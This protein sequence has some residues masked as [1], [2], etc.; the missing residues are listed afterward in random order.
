MAIDTF[1]LAWFGYKKN[2]TGTITGGTF[3]AIVQIQE[4]APTTLKLECKINAFTGSMSAQ[5]AST[6][7][8]MTFANTSTFNYA[9]GTHSVVLPASFITIIGT[10]AQN[11]Y[12]NFRL[13]RVGLTNQTYLVDWTPTGLYL[14][15]PDTEIGTLDISYDELNA[16]SVGIN[17]GGIVCPTNSNAASASVDASIVPNASA[18]T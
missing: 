3:Y 13:G 16:P 5:T 11:D 4:A 7:H 6:L 12:I 15:V 14:N 9:G 10:A 17:Q 18:G 8:T 1:D 2:F